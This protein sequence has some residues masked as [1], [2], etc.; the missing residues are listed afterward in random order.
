MV[1]TLLVISKSNSLIINNL[2]L[3]GFFSATFI[4]LTPSAYR[5]ISYFQM[6]KFTQKILN[7]INKNLE[8]FDKIKIDKDE[9]SKRKK[10]ENI[11]IENSIVIKNIKFS[12]NSK[13]KLFESL[14]LEIKIV[15]TIG[16]FGESGSGKS[17]FVNLLIGLLKP[18]KGEILINDKNINSNIY[19]WRKNIG[20]VPQNIFLID[21][22]F[23]KYFSEF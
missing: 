17:T 14:D 9:K 7:I 23:K 22:T 10:I 3:L 18:D 20:Y 6:I 2:T 1:I 13:K 12:Y 11:S 16:I 4:R 8:Y 5:I 19:L 15:D 21:D